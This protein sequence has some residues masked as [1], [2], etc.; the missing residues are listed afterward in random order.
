MKKDH[1]LFQITSS[2]PMYASPNCIFLLSQ[3]I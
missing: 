1:E 3:S 2:I